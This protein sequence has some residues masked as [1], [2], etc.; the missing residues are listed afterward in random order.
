MI[1]LVGKS[2]IPVN[3]HEYLIAHLPGARFT[4]MTEP[5]DC[6]KAIKSEEEIA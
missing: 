3:F 6:L 2:F 4:D 1:G 5:I